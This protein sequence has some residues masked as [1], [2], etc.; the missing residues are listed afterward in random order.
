[1]TAPPKPS[2]VDRTAFLR[3]VAVYKFVQTAILIGLGLATLRL[4]KPDVAATFALWVQDLPVGYIHH[5][6]ERFLGWISG[7]QSYRVVLVVIALFAYAALFLVEGV[8]LWMQK[9]WAEWLT[10]AATATLIPPEIYEC[11][12]RP[13]LT[14][15][16]LLVVNTTVVWLLA[17]R[18]QHEL[19]QDAL[20]RSLRGD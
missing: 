9:R 11:I 8:G 13:S 20:R 15:F 14:L 7:A 3:V 10:V 5:V 12:Q 6:A 1:M 17:K 2:V 16:A 4:V 18:L 19:A